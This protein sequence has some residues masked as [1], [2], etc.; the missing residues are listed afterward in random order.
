M[1]GA[2]D[3][4]RAANRRHQWRERRRFLLATLALAIMYIAIYE[5][6]LWGAAK[7]MRIGWTYDNPARTYAHQAAEVA[8][9]SKARDTGLSTQQLQ[10]LFQLGLQYG[11]LSRRLGGSGTQPDATM[12]HLRPPVDRN[13]QDLHTRA[14]LLGIGT[15]EPLPVSTAADFLQLT[16]HLEDDVGGVA[17]S[18]ERA[19]SPRL[20]HLFM[21]GVH[22]GTELATLEARDDLMP[23]PP[24]ALIGMHGTLAAVPEPLWR[25]LTRLSHGD[26]A[27]ALGD[28][29]AAAATLD[30]SLAHGTS[31]RS[32]AQK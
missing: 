26:M 31:S 10:S 9:R 27:T 7:L 6:W 2:T 19:T 4:L 3:A 28:Y 20:R 24:F 29:R 25:P 17:A 8:E 1:A 11:Y 12:P 15:I 14:E 21:L 22:V 5:S 30:L 32:P 18:V 16:Q 13:L 23:F